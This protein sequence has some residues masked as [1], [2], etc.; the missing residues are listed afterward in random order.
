MSESSKQRKLMLTGLALALTG[1][2]L[3]LGIYVEQPGRSINGRSPVPRSRDL[4]RL[5]GQCLAF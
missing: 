1:M 4:D 3:S 5:I 2:S